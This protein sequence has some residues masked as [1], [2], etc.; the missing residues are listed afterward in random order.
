[1]EANERWKE[2]C[3]QAST[4]QDPEKLIKLVHEI[5]RL[6]TEKLPQVKKVEAD[7]GVGKQNAA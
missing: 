5:D 6:L 3:K 2:L 7:K 4:E 1:M